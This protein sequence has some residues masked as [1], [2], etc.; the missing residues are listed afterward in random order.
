MISSKSE[1]SSELD[2]F[3]EIF[4]ISFESLWDTINIVARSTVAR[5]ENKMI[6]A[7]KRENEDFDVFFCDTEGFNSLDGINSKPIPG[8]LTLLQL[9]TIS[10]SI[11]SRLINNEDLKE[12][13]SQIQIS[14]YIKK[15]NNSLP[16]P[17]I[18]VYITNILYGN[19][20]EY[21]NDEEQESYEKIKN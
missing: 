21:D 2:C 14:R 12:L 19:E 16:S 7:F 5:T 3:K 13:F 15:I 10:V 6:L 11:S 1:E 9:C 17:L 18:V 20:D 4:W 8:I